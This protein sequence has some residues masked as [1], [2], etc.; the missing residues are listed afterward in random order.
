ML[1]LIIPAYNEEARLPRTLRELRRHLQGSRSVTRDVEVIVV[2]NL[3][4]DATA[5]V[6]LE[7]DRPGFAVRV[8]S[9]PTPGK[10]AAVAAGIAVTDAPL[11]GFMDAD[12]ATCLDALDEAVRLITLGADLALASRATAGSVTDVRDSRLR[13]IGAARYRALTIRLVPGIADT[14]CG[15][16]VMRGDLGRSLFAALRTDGFSFDVELLARA[17]ASGARLTEFPVTWVDVPGSTF[18]PLRH[19]AG[20]FLDLARI[21]WRLRAEKGFTPVTEIAPVLQ[22]RSVSGL[23][24]LSPGGPSLSA[25]ADA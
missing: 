22:L 11:V 8:V 25:L 14:Q 3:S 16:K 5:Q 23:G 1:Q 17:Q 19:G 10:G 12:G 13:E 21:A 2:D 15:F 6:A 20:S 9:C 18:Q 4:T 24:P 7:A